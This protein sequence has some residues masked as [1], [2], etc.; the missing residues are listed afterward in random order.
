MDQ[1]KAGDHVS[2]DGGGPPIDGIVFYLPTKAKAVVAVIDHDRG[3]VM[4]TVAL[5]AL[6]P[7]EGD[8][9]HDEALRLLVR[10]TP[11]PVGAGPGGNGGA[12]HG[13]AG[14]ARAAMHRTTGK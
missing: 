13:S 4:R 10:R 9:P 14:F 2:V 12:V 5:K 8:G 6:T 1:T 7:R 3:P 11:M